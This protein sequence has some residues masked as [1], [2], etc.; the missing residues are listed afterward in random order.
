MLTSA[1]HNAMFH[2]LSAHFPHAHH[3]VIERACTAA[4]RAMSNAVA[5]APAPSP[6]YHNPV[7]QRTNLRA[8]AGW[9]VRK[10]R[11]GMFDAVHSAGSISPGYDTF[12]AAVRFAKY[13]GRVA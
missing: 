8:Y 10:Y 5:P 13:G 9:Q 1:Q 7:I 4:S 6:R 12:H 3:T 2:T 11:D